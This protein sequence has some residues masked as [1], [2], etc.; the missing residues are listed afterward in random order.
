MR[1]YPLGAAQPV[2]DHPVHGRIEAGEDGGFDLSDDL[3][4]ELHSFCHRG[5]RIW[6][7]EDERSE[8]RQREGLA[9]RRDPAA[10]FDTVSGMADLTRQLA[11]AQLAQA[12]PAP[13]NREEEIAALKRR[14]AELEGTAEPDLASGEP[15]PKTAPEP[16]APAKPRSGSAKDPAAAK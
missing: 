1:L 16:K 6:E 2:I 12:A 14:L 3:S 4:D 10:L 13:V 7:T 11:Q 15:E 9:A 5:K 8:R